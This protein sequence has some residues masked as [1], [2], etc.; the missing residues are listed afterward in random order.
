MPGAHRF[1]GC[2]VY[3]SCVVKVKRV[4]ICHEPNRLAKFGPYFLYLPSNRGKTVGVRVTIVTQEAGHRASL[5]M[6]LDRRDA[7]YVRKTKVG[8]FPCLFG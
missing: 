4:Q 7:N 5:G 6:K 2:E 1:H 8:L 3:M